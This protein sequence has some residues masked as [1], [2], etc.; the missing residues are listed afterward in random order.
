MVSGTLTLPDGRSHVFSDPCLT[1]WEA[2]RLHE[3]LSELSR[4]RA[5][6]EGDGP[7][8]VFTEPCLAFAASRLDAE[9]VEIRVYLSLEAAPPFV[10]A[11]S[12]GMV[13]NYVP[14]RVDRGTLGVA[15]AAWAEDL[16]PFPVPPDR[17]GP[18]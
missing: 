4:G 15:A 16:R 14:L 9:R 10:V 1:T 17:D 12:A 2:A 3:W 18:A 6:E 11:G 5:P 8:L 13:E 7:T